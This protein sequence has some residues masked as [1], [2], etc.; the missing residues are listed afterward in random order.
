MKNVVSALIQFNWT[1]LFILS[2]VKGILFQNVKAVINE[3]HKE[4][5]HF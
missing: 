3:Y 1:H 4:N 2:R 5:V